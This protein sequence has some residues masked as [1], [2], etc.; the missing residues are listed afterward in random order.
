MFGMERP[1]AELLP[2]S[3][4]RCPDCQ[5]RMITSAVSD[6][7]EGPEQRV[8]RCVKCGHTKITTLAAD[9]LRSDA[10][11]WINSELRPPM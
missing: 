1:P 9:P 11:G 4:P 8:F 5:A 2:T 3:R 10:V 6:G 7:P